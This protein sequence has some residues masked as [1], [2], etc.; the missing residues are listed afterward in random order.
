[1]APPLNTVGSSK[2]VEKNLCRMMMIYSLVFSGWI[3]V[4]KKKKKKEG[5]KMNGMEAGAVK[6]AQSSM[7]SSPSSD[8]RQE[9]WVGTVW[10]SI[11]VCQSG[12]DCKAWYRQLRFVPG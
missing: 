2:W 1:M 9:P 3:K 10:E 5:E 6:E 8:R 4:K 7:I 12:L 11:S